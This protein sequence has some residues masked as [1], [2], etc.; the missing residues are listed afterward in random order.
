MLTALSTA[1]LFFDHTLA[2]FRIHNVNE[3]PV[4]NQLPSITDIIVDFPVLFDTQFFIPK[5]EN[6]DEI[7]IISMII[8]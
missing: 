4:N 7:I 2:E 3:I 8:T 5:F 1:F 6:T